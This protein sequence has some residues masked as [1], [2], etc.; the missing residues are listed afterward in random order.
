VSPAWAECKAIPKSVLVWTCHVVPVG[1]I[2]SGVDI[3]L[4]KLRH[5]HL[6]KPKCANQKS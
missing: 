6:R 5:W 3:D 1:L 2:E 4:W